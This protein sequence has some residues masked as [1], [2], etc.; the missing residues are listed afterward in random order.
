MGK[1][2]NGIIG[3]AKMRVEENMERPG[4]KRDESQAEWVEVKRERGWKG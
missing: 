3:E 2:E 1:G 4:E